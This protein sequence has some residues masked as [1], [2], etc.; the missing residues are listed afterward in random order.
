MVLEAEHVFAKYDRFRIAKHLKSML[1]HR[2]NTECL[3]CCS[4]PVAYAHRQR[5]AALWAKTGP[6]DFYYPKSLT[7]GHPPRPPRPLSPSQSPGGEGGP[8][9]GRFFVGW[10]KRA[11]PRNPPSSMGNRL[12][13]FLT[14]RDIHSLRVFAFLSSSSRFSARDLLPKEPYARSSPS[15]PPPPLPQPKPWGRGGGQAVG[16]VSLLPQPKPWV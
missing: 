8:S 5:S 15:P 9:G 11:L 3:F 6:S 10:V 12:T 4:V 2:K 13:P 16:G 14:L 7:R 1:A